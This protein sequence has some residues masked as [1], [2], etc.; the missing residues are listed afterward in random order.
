MY[1]KNNNLNISTSNSAFVVVSRK[2]YDAGLESAMA[3]AILEIR[4][5]P[6]TSDISRYSTAIFACINFLSLC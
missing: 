3:V 4:H 5:D 1:H 2:F 6:L